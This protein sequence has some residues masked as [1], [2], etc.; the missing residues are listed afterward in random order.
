MAGLRFYDNG[1]RTEA[2]KRR[3]RTFYDA[4]CPDD[5][6]LFVLPTK[7]YR[8]CKYGRDSWGYVPIGQRTI[9]VC[10][11]ALRRPDW[12]TILEHELLH[13]EHPDWSEEKVR[14]EA[15]NHPFVVWPAE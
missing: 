11:Q 6:W 3:A 8:A 4:R 7:V 5:I 13:I 15:R 14:R 9:M 12:G 2:A 1:G 10:T